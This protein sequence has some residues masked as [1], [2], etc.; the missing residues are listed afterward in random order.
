MKQRLL[1]V[2]G[3]VV[4]AACAAP[5]TP[6]QPTAP[7]AAATTPV[8]DTVMNA[9]AKSY[10]HLVLELGE[11]DEGYVDA[12]YG[13]H[14]WRDEAAA[15]HR[16]FSAIAA[17]A[18]ELVARLAALDLAGREEIVRLRHNYLRRQL[19]ALRSRAEILDGKKLSFD[20]ESKALYDAVAPQQDE[21]DF[22]PALAELD[23]LLPGQGP[24]PER[25]EAMR[26]TVIIAPDRLEVVFATA[27]AECRRRTALHL[28]LPAKERF[29]VEYVTGKP[30]S[31]YNWYQGDDQSLI[32]VNTDLPVTLDRA[33]DL[34]CHEG[35]PGHHVYNFSLEEALVDGRGWMEY[36]VYPLYTPQSL[37]A[38]GTA[39]FGIEV[40]FPGEER[41]AFEIE[42]AA[43]AGIERSRVEH[44]AR[45]Q[46]AL[47]RLSY[48]GNT[49]ARRYLDGEIDARAAADWLERYALTS[50]RARAE[51]RVRF[52]D[53]YRSY[54]INYNLGQDLVRRYVESKGGT[55]QDPARR[56]QVFLELL[57]SPRLPSDL[58]VD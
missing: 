15:R 1:A 6:P 41:T 7:P 49:A 56:W 54:V 23:R 55:A 8:G 58:R 21:K 51:Q 52:F 17:E 57:A 25:I 42:L 19:E 36:T 29:E 26:H 27:I 35:Y 46:K 38:E 47:D 34:A 43:L 2:A 32:Q 39:N 44:Y 10:V 5:P 50:P 48:A 20:E 30:W 13:P 22:E 33:V 40:A 3:F 45:V 12:Y 14:A 4:L 53:T 16:P 28:P 31:A 11:K 37:I 18:T 9:V 24:L